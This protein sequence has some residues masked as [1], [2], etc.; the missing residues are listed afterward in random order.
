VA[1]N[2]LLQK[3]RK[4]IHEKIGRAIEVIWPHRLEEFYEMLA[5]HYSKSENSEKAYKYLKLSGN[6]ATK[7]YS[8]SEAFRFFK[9][10]LEVLSRMPEAEKNI[11]EQIELRLLIAGPMLHLGFPEDSLE[12]LQA[13]ERLSKELGEEKARALLLSLIGQYYAWKGED[14]LQAIQYS[15]KSFKEADKI[16]DG[17][18]MAPIGADLVFLY[19]WMGEYVKAT[20]IASKAISFLEKSLRQADSFGK[21]YNVYSM[22]LAEHATC[23]WRMEN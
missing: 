2:S 16:N 20:D 15:E 17:D 10:A 7:N 13:G 4:E 9:E 1:Y 12:I 3:R 8:N 22:L 18:L 23:S 14:L 6:K 19:F 11:S 5:Y 21:P